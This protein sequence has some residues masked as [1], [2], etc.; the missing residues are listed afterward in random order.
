MSR[1]DISATVMSHRDN[2]LGEAT[3]DIDVTEH[4]IV[5]DG[6]EHD[7]TGGQLGR[8]PIDPLRRD[9]GMGGHRCGARQP[10]SP[11]LPDENGRTRC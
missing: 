4:A 11:R 7:V 9:R 2:N 6:A 5:V 10:A 3:V 1:R 8:G